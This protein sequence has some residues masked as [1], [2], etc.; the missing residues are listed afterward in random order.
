MT[1]PV[2]E[3]TAGGTLPNHRVLTYAFGDIANNLMFSMTSMFIMVYMT[4]IVGISAA[5]AGTIY[6]V[7]KIWAGAADLIAGQTVDR[8]QTKWGRLRPWILFGSTPLAIVFVL[9]F[10]TP[11]GLSGAAAIAWIFLL[12][13][14][15]Q[16][17]YSFVNIPYGSLSASMTQDP[18][19]RS[20]LSGARSI[21]SSLASVLLSAV[22]APQFAD[23]A[24]DNMRL[25]F[26]ITCLVLGVIAVCLYLICFA[27]SR[28]VVPRPEGKISFKSTF[29]MIGQNRPLIILCA[30]TFFLLS[31]MF[32]NNAVA[33]YYTRDVLGNASWFTWLMGAQ[34]VG[35][36]LVATLIPSITVR[37]G[38]RNGFMM[39]ACFVIVGYLLMFII[40]SGQLLPAVV[41]WFLLGIGIGCTNALIFSME[42]DT[43]DYGEWNSSIR[44]EGGTYSVVSFIRKCGQG[45]GGW[46]GGAVIAAFGYTSMAGGAQSV[47]AVQGIRIATGA[48]PA[49]F[50]IVALIIIIAYRLDAGRHAEIIDDLN[51]RRMQNAVA[52]RHGVTSDQ[53]QIAEIG[54]GRNTI[55]R[56]IHEDHPPIITVFGQRGSGASDIAPM[57]AKRLGVTYINQVFSSDTLAQVDKKALIS[58]SSFNRWLRTVSYGSTQDADMAAASNLAANSALARKNTAEVLEA[59]ADGGVM[60]GRNGALVLGPV[61]GTLH[62]KFI[63]P[64]NKRIERVMYKTGLSESAAA[65]QCALE[66]RLRQEMSYALY[67]WNPSRD[68]DYDLVINTGS[69][70]YEQIV[71]LVAETYARKYPLQARII[72]N[73]K[74]V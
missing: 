1:T 11:A 20:K 51:E 52:G 73:D 41:T 56:P 48:I 58:D 17:A 65:E 37:I 14:L 43:V 19:D 62:V 59:V 74:N 32:T 60:L 5:V 28:E 40:P 72:P 68:E 49:G 55:I 10:S 61:V 27:N 12:D 39:A 29:K 71:D 42:A 26:T 7:T 36:I 8:F 15:F 24:A 53:V 33:M 44:A 30:S 47:E 50:A 70:T 45:I 46:I 38:K 25:K 35:S 67:Q 23:T 16:L 6:G 9:L 4:D 54:D 13:A 57:I 21:T 63:A 18:V 3:R 22:V 66:D 2:K 69:M 31:A 64:L 34:T